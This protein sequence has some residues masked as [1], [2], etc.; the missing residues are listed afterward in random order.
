LLLAADE[1]AKGLNTYVDVTSFSSMMKSLFS[2]TFLAFG[3][4][5]FILLPNSYEGVL[6][7]IFPRG[8]VLLSPQVS[9]SSSFSDIDDESSSQSDSS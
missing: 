3:V 4:L 7:L 9:F 1:L 6:V 8:F 5:A 2:F